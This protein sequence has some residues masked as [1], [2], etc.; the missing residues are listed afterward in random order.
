M[1][2][3]GSETRRTSLSEDDPLL[4]RTSDAPWR[5]RFLPVA[6]LQYF[7]DFGLDCFL[8]EEDR[9]TWH[10]VLLVSPRGASRV[11][12]ETL[13][14]KDRERA[15]YNHASFD[16][17]AETREPL[18]STYHGFHDL[19]V[20]VV[21]HREVRGFLASGPFLTEPFVR[22][23]IE[24]QWR[25]LT[26]A[27]PR[28]GEADFVAYV[29]SVLATPMLSPAEVS[30]WTRSLESFAA[31]LTTDGDGTVEFEALR[32]AH[33]EHLGTSPPRGIRIAAEAFIDRQLNAEW[34]APY[35]DQRRRE[36]G[37]EH[38]P[39]AVLVAAP[40]APAGPDAA[41]VDAL[42]RGRAIQEACRAFARTKPSTLAGAFGDASCFLLTHVGTD[43]LTS[44]RRSALMA[45][46][47]ALRETVKARCGADLHVGVGPLAPGGEALPAAYDAALMALQLAVHERRS[48]VFHA[49]RAGE[50]TEAVD[51]GGLLADLRSQVEHGSRA[52]LEVSLDRF[53]RHIVQRSSA[54][55]DALRAYCEMAFVELAEVVRRAAVMDDKGIKEARARVAGELDA[56]DGL[57]AP[58][59]ILRRAVLDIR[60]ALERPADT[61]RGAKV[62]RAISIVTRN[63]DKKLTLAAIAREV[64]LAPGYLS[65]L[66]RQRAGEG[67]ADLRNRLRVERAKVL[68]RTTEMPIGRVGHSSGFASQ[69]HFF[70]AF[71]KLERATPS[72]YRA[73][74]K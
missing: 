50:L 1:P 51:L 40:R 7:A 28:A 66:L 34:R 22:K 5:T 18:C 55:R 13:Y 36:L 47:R 56:S 38:V 14:Q 49:D 37:L 69:Q 2:G 26:G 64:G 73:R 68:L 52:A 23:D 48:V 63:L 33:D 31:L 41:L 30:G 54:S 44:A 61:D 9:R 57:L 8:I 3:R 16:R 53:V 15:E 17:V 72:A 59:E 67:L 12:F 6:S 29:R 27:A 65:K 21:R 11:D 25:D 20:P 10:E 70:A 4:R 35:Y 62:A 42:L 45:V 71:R 43:L 19:F 46:A 24:D 32:K 74:Q 60:T 39:D 58:P